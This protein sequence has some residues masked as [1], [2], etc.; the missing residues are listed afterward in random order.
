MNDLI[1]LIYWNI[2]FPH[3]FMIT[4]ICEYFYDSNGDNMIIPI[5]MPISGC[6]PLR[7][8]VILSLEFAILR[9]LITPLL[10]YIFK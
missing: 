5:E 6:T 3:I 4:F 2:F 1:K 7:A 8:T 10:L 9:H